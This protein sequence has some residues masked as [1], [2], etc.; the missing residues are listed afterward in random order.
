VSFGLVISIVIS[1]FAVGAALSLL[2]RFR[3]WRFG[4]LAGIALFAAAGVLAAEIVLLL[5]QPRAPGLPDLSVFEGLFPTLVLS[6]LALSVMFFLERI[7]R[8]RSAAED[9]LKM[10]Q[11]SLN[12]AG[13]PVFWFSSEGKIHYVNE[14][15]C[16]WLGYGREELL[17]ASIQ[18]IAPFCTPAERAELWSALSEQ[19]SCYAEVY[20]QPKDGIPLPADVTAI[21]I[22]AGG[23]GLACVFA[24]DISGRKQGEAELRIAKNRAESANRAK[25]DF[26][27]TMSHE[28]RTPLNAIIGF[29]EIMQQ[30]M[31]GPLGSERYGAFAGDII[32]SGRHLLCIINNMLDLS[33]AE[34][35]QLAL[36][37]EE[38]EVG[39]VLSQSLRMFREKAKKQGVEL[40]SNE[41]PEIVL[42]ADRQILQQIVI[43]LVSNAVKFTPSGGTVTLSA[44]IEDEAICRLS[45][46][47]TGRGIAE[48]DLE[49]VLEPFVQAENALTRQHE[50]TGLGL[51]LAKKFMELHGGTLTI[52]SSLGGGT[53]VTARF[54]PERLARPLVKAS[55]QHAAG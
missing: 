39:E 26:L 41:M 1:L 17:A 21:R 9:S 55:L 29:S 18:D 35:G 2:W 8:D 48:D 11:V 32:S 28:L 50:G 10:A 6:V 16:T 46:Q 23:Q 3:D 49:R 51:P 33:K 4:F 15:A 45:V 31:Y 25:S 44:G 7:I 20:F 53:T 47:D 19:G 5:L 13:M 36:I 43:N 52:A 34:A 38:V 12:R 40:S 30:E 37:E 42:R 54:P 27:M 14:G 22:S 24:R